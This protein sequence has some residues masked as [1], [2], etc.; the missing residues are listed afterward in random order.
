MYDTEHPDISLDENFNAETYSLTIEQ[1]KEDDKIKLRYKRDFTIVGMVF[2][3]MFPF[4]QVN[5]G[6]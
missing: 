2:M 5:T 3:K 6:Y 1:Y 4:I